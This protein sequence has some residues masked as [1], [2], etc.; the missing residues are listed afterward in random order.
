MSEYIA[1]EVI[2]EQM[3][4]DVYESAQNMV[5]QQR[6]FGESERMAYLGAVANHFPE[7]VVVPPFVLLEARIE[8]GL[9]NNVF[10]EADIEERRHLLAEEKRPEEIVPEVT[11]SYV[12]GGYIMNMEAIQRLLKADYF[13]YYPKR[14][15]QLA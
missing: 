11:F 2:A 8:A 13:N 12:L 3:G 14:A 7:H 10:T 15:G 5:A 6:L 9:A 4:A 1:A